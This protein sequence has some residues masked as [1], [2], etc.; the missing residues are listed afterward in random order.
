[1]CPG[2]K[3]SSLNLSDYSFIGNDVGRVS[4]VDT[5]SHLPIGEL[6]SWR[7]KIA[8]KTKDL[9]VVIWKKIDQIT[10]EVKCNFYIDDL[11]YYDDEFDVC[12]FNIS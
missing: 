9:H 1:M 10:Y 4:Y 7:V 11:T 3:E 8:D 12:F 5:S 6:I 2:E